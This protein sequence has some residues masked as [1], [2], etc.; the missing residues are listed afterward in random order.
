MFNVCFDEFGVECIYALTHV[1]NIASEKL[2]ISIGFS[3]D[4]VLRG[5]VNLNG[6]QQVQKCFTLLKNDWRTS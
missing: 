5:W 4:G 6:E 1:D 2:L 3:L